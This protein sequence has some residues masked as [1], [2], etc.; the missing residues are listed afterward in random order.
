MRSAVVLLMLAGAA[1]AARADAIVFARGSS[2]MRADVDG[3]HET[4]LATFAS[5]GPVRAL[6]TDAGGKV[7]LADIGGVW[8]WMPLDGS[9]KTL[10]SLPCAAG[11]AMLSEDGAAV[12]CRSAKAGAP[13]QV[14]VLATNRTFAV[15]VPTAGARP[16]DGKRLVWADKGGVWI[17]PFADL[18]QKKLVA[19][20]APKHDFLP[21]G[22]GKRAVGVYEGDAFVDNRHK[23]P[24]D[25]LM[26]FQL[27]GIGARRRALKNAVPLDWSHDGVYV[28]MQDGASA[29]VV[30]SHGGEYKC[31][32]GYTAQSTSPDAKWTLILGNRDGPKA[33]AAGAAK[34]GGAAKAGAGAK[35]KTAKATGAKVPPAPPPAEPP[36]VPDGADDADPDAPDAGSPPGPE[37]AVTPPSGPQSLYKAQLEGLYTVKPVLIVKVV[38]GAA[39]WVPGA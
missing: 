10:V 23:K 34:S 5:K 15:D 38:D 27:D 39:V 9:T 30:H 18:R 29:C 12:A 13:T 1:S 33:P 36:A 26:Q 6:R 8:G 35:G 7:L 14:I 28:V 4:E 32:S 2:L 16:L 11:P 17:A 22:D 24:I 25:Q 3:K 20:E 19:P 31:W 37:V 21:S